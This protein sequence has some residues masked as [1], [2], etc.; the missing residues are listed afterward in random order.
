MNNNIRSR[1]S[2]FS[3]PR[4][5]GSRPRNS[6]SSNISTSMYVN[7]AVEI[8]DQEP[9]E[10]THKFSDFALNQYIL[11][12]V[13]ARKYVTPTPIQDQCIPLVI[14]GK[15]VIGIADT[16]TGKTAAFLLPL[17][18]KVMADRTQKVLI[19]VPTRELAVQIDEEFKSFAQNMRLYSALCLGGSGYGGQMSA[20]RRNPQFVIGTPGRL[21]DFVNRRML[22][23]NDFNNLVLD[24]ADRMVDM[25]FINDV[26]ELISRLPVERQSLFF[27]AT[28]SSEVRRLIQNFTISPTSVS[29][30]KRDTSQNVDQDI[31]RF[32][33][34]IHKMSLLH[35]IL[36][37]ED[38]DKALIFGRTKHGVEKLS[39]A[40]IELGF[41]VTS[42][43]GNK[44]QSQRQRALN[45][46]K[47]NRV[48]I[49]VAT[50]V[51]ARGLDIPNVSHV[52]NFDAPEQ[53]ADYI[54]RIG[55]TGR[56]N[57]TGKALTF[58]GMGA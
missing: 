4:S 39:N 10:I 17:I 8:I 33:D 3:R 42:I 37:Q 13:S 49:M 46:F 43:H 53:Y 26:R 29:V 21:K 9:E 6:R 16:G 55:R 23:L 5:Y 12:R 36:N 28:I 58:V 50:D 7:K 56:A 15:D 18:N 14:E 47:D 1:H 40:L 31:V 11:D 52:I 45:D 38:C 41:G 57:K 27:S 34:T 2:G 24:E 19:I 35:N 20:L 25:G 30:K 22:N 32:T 54:H 48:Q 51:A 44:S